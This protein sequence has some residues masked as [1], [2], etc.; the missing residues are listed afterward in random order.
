VRLL[1]ACLLCGLLNLAAQAHASASFTVG[2]LPIHSPRVLVTRYEPLRAYLQARLGQP[3]RVETAA[4]FARFHKRTL[5]GDF[6]LTI[7]PAHFARLAQLEA[8]FQP[9]A[10][11]TPDHDA[12]L[13]LDAQRPLRHLRELRGKDFAVV[14]RL[15]ITVMAGVAHL[16]EQGLK[17]GRDYR[18][19]E[20][21]THASVAHAV[22]QGLAAAGITTTQGLMQMTPELRDRIVVHRHIADIPAFVMLARPGVERAGAESLRKLLLAFP[23]DASGR[24]FLAHIGYGAIHP[25]DEAFMKRGD[26]YLS[27]TR[28]ALRQ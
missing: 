10:H 4:D 16:E 25:A 8:G 17:A 2:V 20:H 28:K 27:A 15:A 18:V 26:A 23:G 9:L 11:F 19:V 5:R 6:D 3:V 13:I 22:A 21:R 7:T 1:I 24:V 14:D 12:L